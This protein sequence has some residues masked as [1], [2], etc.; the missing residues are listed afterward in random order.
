MSETPFLPETSIVEREHQ[1]LKR[2]I[3]IVTYITF[4]IAIA[5][6]IASIVVPSTLSADRKIY[7]IDILGVCSIG[8]LIVILV[9]SSEAITLLIFSSLSTYVSLVI[10]CITIFY[11][12]C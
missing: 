3:R 12:R 1:K 5:V 6:I 8:I 7:V 10:L 2:A 11:L 4:G 9:S